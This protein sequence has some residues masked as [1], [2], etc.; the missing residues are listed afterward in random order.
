MAISRRI[1][2]A[3]IRAMCEV[4]IIEKRRGQGLM[5]LLSIKD[6]LDGLARGS[7]I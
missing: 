7:G 1:K 5:S 6:T 3:M 2:K 4:K